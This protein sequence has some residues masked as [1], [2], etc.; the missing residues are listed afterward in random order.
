VDGTG[1]PLFPFGYGLSYS[2]FEYS[3]LKL[4]R[5]TFTAKDTVRITFTL[6]NTG[7]VAGE[8]VVQL[9]THD[10][11]ASVARPVKELKG[12]QRV[13]LEAG[14]TRTVTFTLTA[15]KLTLFNQAMEEVTEPGMFRIMIGGSSKDIRLRAMVEYVE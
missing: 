10:E 3:D 5:A 14:E 12:F 1:H 7:A 15:D 2:T 11:L 9:Y 6:K 13:S 4:S 8:E